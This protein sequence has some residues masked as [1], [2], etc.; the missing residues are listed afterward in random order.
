[1]IFSLLILGFNKGFKLKN[2][3]EIK[4]LAYQ[5]QTYQ[6]VVGIHPRIHAKL[7]DKKFGFKIPKIEEKLNQKYRAYDRENDTSNRKQHYQGTQTWIGLHPQVLQTPYNNILA[8]LS[9]LKD[10]SVNTIVDI[11]AGYGRVGLVM[12]S[13]FPESTF[14]GYEII[15]KREREGNRIFEKLGMDNCEIRN[16]NVLEDGFDIPDAEVYFI[17]DFSEK[18]DLCQILDKLVKKAKKKK[19]YLITHGDR[20]DFLLEK[21][22]KMF[23]N[24]NGFIA[25]DNLRIYQSA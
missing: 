13:V 14:I 9:K 20:I 25:L 5:R 10:I 23:W 17:Y 12:N 8:C 11:G 18:E 7:L 1:M 4:E 24:K 3:A 2:L 15:N 16:Q 6:S 22:Y 19:F 21:K